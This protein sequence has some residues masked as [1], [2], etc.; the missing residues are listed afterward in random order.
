MKTLHATP[1]RLLLR[2][3]V[4]A[5]SGFAAVSSALAQNPA[6]FVNL[7]TTQSSTPGVAPTTAATITIA[8]PGDG[9]MYGAAAP[10]A[11][12]TWNNILSPNAADQIKPQPLGLVQGAVVPLIT[13][14]DIALTQPDGSASGVTLTASAILNDAGT[15]SNTREVPRLVNVSSATPAG[16]MG[17]AWRIYEG[18]NSIGLAFSGLPADAHYVVYGYAS[19]NGAAQGA[20]FALVDANAVALKW[21]ETSPVANAAPSIFVQNAGEFSP[22]PP[23][24][25]EILSNAADSANVNTTWG[26][27]HAKV[28]ATGKLEIRVSRNANNNG[29]P[30][31]LQLVPYPKAT[32]TAPPSPNAS[33]TVGD[34]VTLTVA[35][36]GFD[37][38]DLLTYHWRKAG[39]P[40]D[41]VANPSAA[42]ASLTLSN[43][44]NADA[45][46]Y[47][48][49]ITN[50][51]GD[52]ISSATALTITSSA[53]APSLLAQPTAQTAAVGGN[54]TFTVSANG[55]SPLTFTWQKSTTSA[56]TGFADLPDSNSTTLS[57]TGVTGADAG[58]YRVRVQNSADTVISDAVSLI[59]APAITA[60]P[61]G[62]TVVE[63]TTTTLSLGLDVGTGAP[64][65]TTYVWKRDGVTVVD[66]AGVSGASTASLQI[67]GF[68]PAQSGYYTVT[69]SN[70]AGSVTSASVY[71]GVVSTQTIT[72]APGNNATQLAVDQQLRLV[73]PSAP[74]LGQS[75]KLQIHDAADDSVVSTVDISEFVSF[76]LFSATIANSKIQT[77]D[78]KQMYYLPAAVYG[79]EVWITLPAA[80]R[81]AYGKTYY[82][83][84]DAG[85]LLDSNNASVP[86]ITGSTTWRFSTKASGP[87]TPTAST[88]PSEI[89]VAADGTGDFATIQGAIDWVP[90]NN[91]LPRTIRVLPGVYR[92]VVYFAQGRDLVTLVGSG[93]SRTDAKVVYHYGNE[94]YG[95]GARGLGG[96]RIDTNDVTVRNITFDNEVYVAVPDLAG[97]SGPG[98]PAFAGP[99]QTVASTGKRLVFDNVLI[100]GGQDTLYA[101]SG[102]A[103][104]NNCEIWGSVD[105]IYGDAL[106][107]FDHCDI[108]EIRDTGGP[109]CAPSTPYGQPYGE[110]FLNCRFPRAL[111]ANGYPYDVGA[112]TT[113]F[114]RPWRQDGM[115]AIINSQLDTQFSAKG[116]S[117]WDGRENTMRAREYGNTLI[118]GGAAPTPAQRQAAGA[119]W[120]NTIDPDYTASSMAP[121]DPLLVSPG[122]I[123]NRQPVT[124]DPADYTLAAIFGHAYFAADLTGWTP[125]IVPT[126]S[127]AVTTQPASQTVVAG[128][129]VTFTAAGTGTPAPTYQWYKNGAAI[130]GAVTDSF[131]IAS[132]AM[133]DAADY[134]VVLTNNVGTATS[135]AAT[136]TV[137]VVPT[138][139]TQ[140]AGKTAQTGEAIALTVA[141]SGT[142]APTYQWFKDGVA[143][144]DATSDSFVIASA[145]AGDSGDYTVVLTNSAGSA[146]SA[147]ATVSVSSTVAPTT[148][149]TQP[150]NQAVTDGQT[151]TFAVAAQGAG[152]TYQWKKDAADIAGATSASLVLSAVGAADQGAYS[153]VVTG[154]GGVVTSDPATLTVSERTVK[155]VFADAFATGST[156]NSATPADPT[157]NST[158]YQILSDKSYNPT[159]AISAT[160]LK[161]GLSNTSSGNVEAQALFSPSPVILSGVGDYI[162]LTA[163]LT[164]VRGMFSAGN[165]TLFVGLYD[166]NQVAPVAGGLNST[167]NGGTFTHAIGYVR[168][169]TGYVSRTIYS[170]GSHQ[171]TTRIPQTGNNNQNQSLAS[172]AYRNPGGTVVG[173]AQPSTL[174]SFPEGAQYTTIFRIT[175]SGAEEYTIE[176]RLLEGAGTAGTELVSYSGVATAATFL[177]DNADHLGF[178]ALAFGARVSG[179]GQT[180]EINSVNIT[181][182]ASLVPVPKITGQP[183]ALTVAVGAPATFSVVAE[184]TGLTYQWFKDDVAISGATA[185]SFTLASAAGTDQGQ[186][187]VVVTNDVHGRS[188][189]ARAELIVD[190]AAGAPAPDGFAHAVTGGGNRA[191]VVVST[192]ADF[193]TYAEQTDPAVITISG[194][195]DL[196]SVGGSIAVMSNKTI[197]GI[198]QNATIRGT[199]YLGSG[200]VNNV[201]IR[202]LNITNPGSTINEEGKYADGGDGISVRSATNVFITHCTVYDCGDGLIDIGFGSDNVTV[203]WCEFYYT[204]AAQVHRFTMIVGNAG[205]EAKPLHITLHHNLWHDRCDQRMPSGS[206]GYVHMFNNYWNTPGNSYAS[207]IRDQG[208][209]FSE[210]NAYFQVK[211]PLYKQ[212]TDPT[213]PGGLIRAIGNVYSEVTGIE[214]DAGT[215]LVF[216]PD[217][218]YQML[219]AADV[220]TVVL[221]GAGNTAGAAS[222]SLPTGSATLTGPSGVVPVN[223]G[224]TLTPVVSDFTPVSYQWRKDNFAI[225]GATTNTFTV[226]AMKETD[227]GMYA[228]AMTAAN[229]DTLVSAPADVVYSSALV[230]VIITQPTNQTATAGSSATF[231]VVAGGDDPLTYQWQKKLNG[232]FVNVTGAASSSF[233]FVSAQA[234]HAGEYRVVVTNAVGTATS[235][236]VSLAVDAAATDGSSGGD[237]GGGGGGGG[238]APS[239]WF[240]GAL[241]LLAALRRFHRRD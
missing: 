238:G 232:S 114:C 34:S 57:L 215:D 150:T 186:Y 155:T 174:A 193:K 166:S 46:S 90:Q 231:T 103:Y 147:V 123:T 79:N 13:A 112:G 173:T 176:S 83:T 129:P 233:G 225:A 136:L 48:V 205:A 234:V 16:L 15:A 92:D 17:T 145:T 54:A 134:T 165:N 12:E 141:G 138:I 96:L 10:Y 146:T 61:S 93:T 162:E 70:S 95:S 188:T 41:A 148:I 28:D 81:L 130:A 116:W 221:T 89:T 65:A 53:V 14:H 167:M 160:G 206:Y 209:F 47:D 139:T 11:G 177:T 58:Y 67:T 208:Q 151:V 154:A 137:T 183:E 164:N 4:W 9:W 39:A 25:S 157:E 21:F 143:I 241:A 60:Q 37:A 6:V 55:T 115:V 119:Y 169:W 33:G 175:R 64:E 125:S 88:G 190:I 104:F 27:L 135:A 140:P 30:N 121:T 87:G 223:T 51:G 181:T 3:L 98:A 111:V 26:V 94:V 216:T 99:I 108:V 131:T 1:C 229:G 226:T 168:N 69:A 118:G 75:G 73:F 109:V 203:S 142:P 230:P 195:L 182:N 189:S 180:I 171:I 172:V 78:G 74:K 149:V 24:P 212:N 77:L 8:V 66:G 42:T 153:V 217:Y 204:E 187:K 219:T 158:A 222:A 40:I 194:T 128:Q 71:L 110:V 113:S 107:V 23:A 210:N 184:G 211:S 7:S 161:F 102:I 240:F 36:S 80:Q 106:A 220:P 152:L 207:N 63:G 19:T 85:F 227:A 144:V 50:Y 126:G 76:T 178:D 44:Q 2:A 5:A 237:A 86:A 197:Q 127:P 199:L 52:A 91:T 179:T 20:H 49:V 32:I 198:D 82:V 84:M 239:F 156:V 105:F 218:S 214:P 72:F 38:S 68:L 185:A 213:L 56:T 132:A 29:F 22:S 31:G 101:I 192:P 100:K 18:G 163:T 97:G 200:D 170:G 236:T 122:G 191:A 43:L 124:V 35:A 235:N 120:L 133:S 228:L 196:A 59:V 45:G 62:G 201:L 117:E 159:P 202:G 224:F